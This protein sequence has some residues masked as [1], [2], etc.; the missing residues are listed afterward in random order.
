MKNW[1]N[2]SWNDVVKELDSDSRYGLTIDKIKKNTEKFG[3]NKTLNLKSKSFIILVLKQIIKVYSISSMLLC[4]LLFKTR[5]FKMAVF[6]LAITSICIMIYSIKDYKN[7]NKLNNL[8]KI[9]PIKADIIRDGKTNTINAEE[10]VVGDIVYLEIGDIVPADLRIIEYDNFKIRESAITGDNKIVDKYETKIEEKEILPSEMKNMVFKSSFVME[11]EAK[12]IVVEVGENTQ[13]G[14]ITK[15]LLKENY[16]TNIVEKNISKMVNILSIIFILCSLIIVLLGFYNKISFQK[17]IQLVSLVYL[18]MVP[19]QIM[20]IISL[21]SFIIKNKMKKRK[22]E[23]GGLSSMQIL[24][25]TNVLLFNKVGALTEE[26]MYIKTFFS[27]GKI[28]EANSQEIEEN[29]DNIDRILNIGVLCN[30]ARV[31]NEGE[32][33]KGDLVER[34]FMIYGK[35]NQLYKNSLEMQQERIFQSPFDFDKKIK[36][37]VNKIDDKVRANV[38]GAVDKLLERCTH[39]MK[40][41]IEVEITSKDIE[42]IKNA[43]LKLSNESLYI[44]GCAYRNFKYQPSINENVESNLVFVGLAGFENPPK[45][46]SIQWINYCRRLAI[47]PIIITNDNKI[48]AEAVGK[49]IN[50]LNKNDLVLSGVEIDNMDNEQL[51]KFVEKVGVYSKISEKVKL[52][53]ANQFKKLGYKLAI[54]GNRFTDLPSFRVAH[55]G[56]AF[57][58]NITNIA[59]KLADI[60]IEENDFIKVLKLIE[61]SR[62][63]LKNIKNILVFN[64]V[65]AIVEF[66]TILASNIVNKG[67]VINF[68]QIVFINFVTLILNS[69][70]LYSQTD[71]IE[72]NRYETVNID[73]SI[74]NNFKSGIILYIVFATI[75]PIVA[76]IM[77]NKVNHFIGPVSMF[78]V[79]NFSSL[80]FTFYFLR[81]KKVIKNKLSI[82]IFLLNISS[83][84]IFLRILDFNIIT[85]L[86][87]I[88]YSSKVVVVILLLEVFLVKCIKES[89]A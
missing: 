44:V 85:T 72:G 55:V 71:N 25:S 22:I 33:K 23:F 46:Q 49:K 86:N 81:I 73:R 89:D 5:S 53:I 28:I 74:F 58:E 43:D 42:N 10:L 8:R 27:N 14:S 60:V 32:V 15:D 9:A 57:G 56:I 13:I 40:N 1:Y 78:T 70:F 19:M 4:I 31:N 67:I 12:G 69:L 3:N 50:I 59:R 38:V 34:A 36:T 77:Q 82:A 87:G 16:E 63:L 47:K 26:R 39:I 76:F 37:T 88:F 17:S 83:Y 18:T 54:M 41:G 61:D 51:E 65:I 80:I 7:Q 68:T 24:S 29:K 84:L 30:D 48:T 20:I 45:E 6:L 21:I 66:T 64:L 11:G 79:L 35:R 52:R 62:K 75:A 2:Y